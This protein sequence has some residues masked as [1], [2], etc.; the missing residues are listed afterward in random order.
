[1]DELPPKCKI[2]F[3]LVRED[4]L[5]YKE[6]AEVLGVSEKTIDAQ[7]VIA[8]KRIGEAVGRYFDYFPARFQKNKN[9]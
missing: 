3:K 9:F 1:M 8:V 4:G 5:K 7:M 2:I 6:A